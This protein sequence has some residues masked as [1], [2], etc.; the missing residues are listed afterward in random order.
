MFLCSFCLGRFGSICFFSRCLSLSCLQWLYRR[1]SDIYY[2]SDLLIDRSSSMNW[3]TNVVNS[4]S[5]FGGIVAN[6]MKSALQI[7]S[8]NNN[9]KQQIH[10]QQQTKETKDNDSNQ[11]M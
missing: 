6:S 9:D 7:K 5:S 8:N 1:G 10:I 11:D 3:L 2:L 4:V